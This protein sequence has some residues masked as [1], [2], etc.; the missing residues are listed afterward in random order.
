MNEWMNEWIINLSIESVDMSKQ[1]EGF[2]WINSKAEQKEV[3]A[4]ATYANSWNAVVYMSFLSLNFHLLRFK[5]W[6][7]LN[8][9]FFSCS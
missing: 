7:V 5:K 8:F 1:N 4:S 9:R 3:L 2:N 6:S